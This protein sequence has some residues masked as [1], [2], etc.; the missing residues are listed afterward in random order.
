MITG[1]LVDIDVTVFQLFL[2]EA[3]LLDSKLDKIHGKSGSL[4]EEKKLQ[5]SLNIITV[6]NAN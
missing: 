2:A 4:R 3:I 5:F 6:L 1:N